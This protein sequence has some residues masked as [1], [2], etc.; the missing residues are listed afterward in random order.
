MSK[1]AFPDGFLTALVDVLDNN[2]VF[3]ELVGPESAADQSL[4][5]KANF[6]MM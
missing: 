4:P 6:L 1:V 2:G 3:G 5:E